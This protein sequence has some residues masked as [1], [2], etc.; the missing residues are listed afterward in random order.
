MEQVFKWT[1][2]GTWRPFSESAEIFCR[3]YSLLFQRRVTDFGAEKSFEK[4]ARQFKEHY[5]F[6]VP[7]STVRRITEGHGE[8]IHG[9]PDLLQG[10]AVSDAK[11]QLVGE[12]D[13][14]MVPIVTTAPTQDGDQRKTRSTCWK[15]VRLALVYE[16]WIGQSDLWRHHRRPNAGW[17]GACQLCFTCWLGWTDQSSRR[18]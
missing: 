7:E 10:E 18:W 15:E 16:P 8:A 6:D 14:T 1:A 11:M 9:H 5:G 2:G 17:R 12:T 4:A 3:G 13:G